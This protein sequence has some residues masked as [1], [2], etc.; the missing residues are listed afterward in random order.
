MQFR[1]EIN[2]DKSPVSMEHDHRILSMGSCFASN[3]AQYLKR[4][5]FR[6]FDNPFGVLYNPVSIHSAVKLLNENK[7]FKQSD[8]I[9]HDDEWHSFFHHSDFSHHVAETCIE[10]LNR[11]LSSAAEFLK[12][13]DWLILTYGTSYV[14]RH[15]QTGIIVSNCHKIPSSE[16]D[17]FRLSADQVYDYLQQTL[18]MLN[19][20]NPG[21]KVIITVSPVRHL[22]DGPVE[23]QLSKS[24]LLLAE[25]KI[26]NANANCFYFP[27]YEIMMDDLRDYRFYDSDLIHPNSA[28]TDYIWDKFCEV[29]LSP[30]TKTAVTK[31]E[32]LA[33]ARAHRVRNPESPVHQKFLDKQ[34]QFIGALKNEY[35][36]LDLDEDLQYFRNQKNT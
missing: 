23:N 22:K 7:Q 18:R 31:L 32:K 21:I 16:F 11:E 24:T 35:T 14:Y 4:Y 15:K 25:D 10:K 36:Y 6:I 8:L 27:S 9:F 28:A 20:I 33:S 12:T 26:V 17:H 2:P 13:T 30:K 19:R 1:T 34:I 3:I 5:R 29:W